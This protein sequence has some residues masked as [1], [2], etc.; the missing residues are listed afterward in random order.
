MNV[1]RAPCGIPTV[2]KE[3]IKHV[4][5]PNDRPSPQ[6]QLVSIILLGW[7]GLCTTQTFLM[8]RPKLS[9]STMIQ[10]IGT[11]AGANVRLH[12]A[13]AASCRFLPLLVSVGASCLLT[14]QVVPCSHHLARCTLHCS[15]HSTVCCILHFLLRPFVALLVAVLIA[16]FR[17]TPRWCIFIMC[18]SAQIDI[19]TADR[20]ALLIVVADPLIVGALHRRALDSGLCVCLRRNQ[21]RIFIR[22]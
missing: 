10:D 17:C 20:S 13:L 4:A 2:A 16:P 1:L 15:S 19:Y 3:M 7:S 22:D 14:Y 12:V 11:K 8:K 18:S 21:G 6:R 9:S 5:V